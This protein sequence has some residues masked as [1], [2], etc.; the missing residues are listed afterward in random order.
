MAALRMVPM[1]AR[2]M[3]L[4]RARPADSQWLATTVDRISR[5]YG[6]RIG[7]EPGGTLTL[8]R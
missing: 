8:R 7:L 4:R 6:S 1:Q 3:Q 5:P 2:K